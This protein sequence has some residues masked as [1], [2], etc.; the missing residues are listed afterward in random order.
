MEGVLASSFGRARG[1]N[2]CS[3]AVAEGEAQ[4]FKLAFEMM[5]VANA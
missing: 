3:K 4:A 1:V 5:P 2:H